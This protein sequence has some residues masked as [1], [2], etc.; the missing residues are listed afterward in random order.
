MHTVLCFVLV[1]TVH[2]SKECDV[3]VRAQQNGPRSQIQV[4]VI[5]MKVLRSKIFESRRMIVGL[6]NLSK[7]EIWP[8]R[9]RNI[10]GRTQAREKASQALT[11]P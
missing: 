10:C 7:Y 9:T 6:Q 1:L 3:R 2:H 5:S 11:Y 4:P 8:V